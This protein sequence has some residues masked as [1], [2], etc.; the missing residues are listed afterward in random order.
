MGIW[1]T[2]YLPSYLPG[3]TVSAQ[4][5][6]KEYQTKDFYLINVHYPYEGELPLTDK[7]I[8][9][10]MLM[11]SKDSLPPEKDTKIVLY[12]KT[13]NMSAKALKTLKSLGYTNVSHLGGG[14]DSW[15]DKGFEVLDLATLPGKVTPQEG[16]ELSFS[17]GNLGPE[18]VKLGV[19][20][21]A[22]FEKAVKM[23]SKEK[24]MLTEGSDEKMVINAQNSQYMVDILWA[25]GLAQKSLAYREGPMGTQYKNEAGNFASTGG[26]TLSSGEAMQHYNA[27][28]LIPLTDEQEQKVKEISENVYRPCCG[29]HTFFPDCNH[30]MAALA[31]L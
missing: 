17:L 8:E 23:T 26:W 13:G 16:I 1:A 5:L 22:K 11:A 19:I 3:K 27:H 30:G 25:L 28:T 21:M 6:K 29:N 2:G 12:C 4:E 7:F 15:R 24:E 18:L 14:M 10:D 31:C 20:N 9:Y